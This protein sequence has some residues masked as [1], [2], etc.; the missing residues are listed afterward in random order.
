MSDRNSAIGRAAAAVL[1]VIAAGIVA[2]ASAADAAWPTHLVRIV[3]AQAAGGTP[4]MI[5]RFIADP[6][7]RA[8]D[9]P[10]VVENR[11]GANGIIGANLVRQ[12]PADGYTLMIGTVS[13]LVL[14]PMVTAN[15][16]FDAQRDFAPVANLFRSV[17]VLWINAALPITNVDE[18]VAYARARAGKLNYASGGVGSTNH[19]DMEIFNGE[20]GIEM[21]H[22]P[23]NG[24]AAAIAAVASGEAQAMIV[25]I[26]GGLALAQAG[27]VR[28]LAIFA[29]KRSPL[30]PN[31]PTAGELR[32]KHRDLSAWIGLV[33][34]AGTPAP[35]IAR[36]NGDIATVLRSPEAV[37]WAARQGLEIIGGTP[38]DYAKELADDL[39]EWSDVVKKMRLN[40]E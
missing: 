27:K 28:G 11:P 30:L 12:S 25:S 38:A 32:L 5:A 1:G 33:A 36:I 16:P 26:G 17:K 15:V 9:V 7:A 13:T 34:P 31:T 6:L 14:T 19:I 23:Y 20:T 3:V 21:V 24:P 2:T 39:V 37:A 10:V 40:R 29:E 22:V 35:V 18:W 4:D 8:L